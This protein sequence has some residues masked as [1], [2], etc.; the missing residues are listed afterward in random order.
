MQSKVK[1]DSNG[2]CD[3]ADDLPAVYNNSHCIN[4]SHHASPA[5]RCGQHVVLAKVISHGPR[6]EGRTTANRRMKVC[7]INAEKTDNSR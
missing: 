7:R 1:A 2:H 4:M 3:E 6:T 5:S